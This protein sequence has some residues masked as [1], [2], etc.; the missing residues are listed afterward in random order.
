MRYHQPE[1]PWRQYR[2]RPDQH[3]MAHARRSDSEARE[4]RCRARSTGDCPTVSYCGTIGACPF[5]EGSLRESL[6]VTSRSPRSMCQRISNASVFLILSSE[7]VCSVTDWQT[8]SNAAVIT[9]IV[10]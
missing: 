7:L 4:A 10:S 1:N 9:E 3:R 6:G 5:A 2:F 8:V